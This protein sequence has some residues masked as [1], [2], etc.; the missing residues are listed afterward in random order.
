MKSAIQSFTRAIG[1]ATGAVEPAPAAA[2]PTP[3]PAPSATAGEGFDRIRIPASD[4]SARELTK[5]EFEA[6]P[7][8]ERVRLLM[9]GKLQFF[10]EGKPVPAREAL[11]GR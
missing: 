11:K 7:L 4:G 2:P 9:G 3:P 6:L 8:G 10:R 1:A 5:A